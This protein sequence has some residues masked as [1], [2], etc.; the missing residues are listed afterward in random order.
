MPTTVV[1]PTKWARIGGVSSGTFSTARE[2]GFNVVNNLTTDQSLAIRYAASAG[3]G[4]LTHNFARTFYYFDLSSSPDLTNLTTASLDINGY[5]NADARVIIVSSSAFGGDGS[6]N[7]TTGE[8]FTSLDYN[9]PYSATT[10]QDWST[11]T[12]TFELNTS[13][14]LT[15]LKSNPD[16]FIF[17]LIDRTNDYSNTA[18]TVAVGNNEGIAFSDHPSGVDLTLITPDTTNIDNINGV[19]YNI[20]NRFSGVLL[21]G[22]GKIN[23]IE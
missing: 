8:F 2:T 19:S 1:N 11:G 4:S 22:I 16:A 6:S 14:V 12:N 21:S 10:G 7:A 18:S 23:G 3:R 15:Y 17:A 9:Q 20:N 13:H 5:V